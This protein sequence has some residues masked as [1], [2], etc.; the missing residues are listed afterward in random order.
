MRGDKGF[1][2]TIS[3]FFFLKKI[4]VC[5]YIAGLAVICL[6]HVIMAIAELWLGR[7]GVYL[8][9]FYLC[10]IAV[11]P[12]PLCKLTTTVA[13]RA[14][15]NT[16]L[17]Q[18]D[19]SCRGWDE[20]RRITTERWRILNM[21]AS[22][23]RIKK[24]TWWENYKNSCLHEKYSRILHISHISAQN[25]DLKIMWWPKVLPNMAHMEKTRFYP[26][27]YTT[28]VIFW[29]PWDDGPLW[30]NLTRPSEVT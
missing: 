23:V 26:H 15:V 6:D 18:S 13:D 28:P 1:M 29:L 25:H 4:Y 8:W 19:W 12:L 9:L 16:E 22:F 14:F 3:S 20:S 21:F 2:P 24:N 30:R 10:L 7:K 27:W 11:I 5:Y 17:H